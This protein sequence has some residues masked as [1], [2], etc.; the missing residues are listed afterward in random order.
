[1]TAVA[2]SER[3]NVVLPL[4]KLPA[5]QSRS[6]VFYRD[7]R[8]TL[9]RMKLIPPVPAVFGWGHD[10]AQGKWWMLGNGPVLPGEPG[11][12]LPA[13]WTAALKGAGDCT[14]AGK[15]HEIMEADKNAGRPI[16]LIGPRTCIEH[17]RLLTQQ[18]GEEYNPVT[19]AGDSGLDIQ[20]VNEWMVKEGFADDDEVYHHILD[21]IEI[22]AGNMLHIQEVAYL[23]GK[24]GM[25]FILQEAQMS[26]FDERAQPT[27]EYVPGSPDIGGHYVPKMGLGAISWS[28]DV[29]LAPSFIEN[30]NDESYGYVMP[31]EYN[32]VTKLSITGIDE[33]DM[34][35]YLVEAAQQKAGALRSHSSIVVPSAPQA[36]QDGDDRQMLWRILNEVR[37]LRSHLYAVAKH[38]EDKM[39]AAGEALK[40]QIAEVQASETEISE[41][42][43]KAG[44]AIAAAVTDIESLNA[45][46]AGL[47]SG[48]ALSD[49]EAASL[50]SEAEAVKNG[51]ATAATELTAHVAS[52]AAADG[53]GTTEPAAGGEDQVREPGES[54]E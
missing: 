53:S 23:T 40:N 13:G 8:P 52:L 28:E 16:S 1:M 10:F 19:G 7:I 54:V 45:K 35:K 4:G 20:A 49:E 51:L 34:E 26:Q 50:K 38:L 30:R 46:I 5:S 22:D 43:V 18:S 6:R 47:E 14:I 3:L 17:Y 11:H 32:A 2:H 36:N 29:Y 15:A 48:V 9:Q 42:V 24:V 44:E 27:W 12:S 37:G 31:D 41:D 39:D 21:P 25:G 33:A